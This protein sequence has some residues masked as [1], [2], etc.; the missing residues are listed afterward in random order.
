MKRPFSRPRFLLPVFGLTAGLILSGCNSSSVE[1]SGPS[2]TAPSEDGPLRPP[3]EY[4]TEILSIKSKETDPEIREAAIRDAMIRHGF[5]P[6]APRAEAPMRE[7]PAPRV[8]AAEA[9][10]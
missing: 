6:A 7:R 10:A 5:R 3:G 1:P 2:G 9:T 4:E 8:A